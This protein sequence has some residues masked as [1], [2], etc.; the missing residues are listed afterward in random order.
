MADLRS[1]T[2]RN[3]VDMFCTTPSP[4]SLK[5]MELKALD[6]KWPM[7]NGDV[8]CA[9]PHAEET[10][11]IAV[12]CPPEYKAWAKQQIEDGLLDMP[13]EELDDCVLQLKTNLYGRRTAGRNWRDK[14]EEVIKQV[15]EKNFKRSASD[16][17]VF[18][19]QIT[20]A[21]VTHH[22][23]DIRG[24]GPTELCEKVI[25]YLSSQL[26]VRWD[27]LETEGC[28]GKFLKRT[29][30]RQEKHMTTEP[31]EKHIERLLDLMNLKDTGGTSIVPGRKLDLKN[32]KELEGDAISHYRSCVG[33][34]MYIAQDRPDCK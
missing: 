9:Y 19:D 11:M 15:P 18:V 33:L 7:F 29:K 24:T 17:C 13:E 26:W 23:D 6:R 31:N 20:G 25:E 21:V 8:T 22:V 5:I 34:A 32:N 1:K 16:P 4:V 10:A 2:D 12:R 3:D 30:R 14:F 27:P 28:V